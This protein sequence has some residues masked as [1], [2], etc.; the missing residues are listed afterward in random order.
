M[1]PFTVI[2]TRK[3]LLNIDVVNHRKFHNPISYLG[4]PRL[5]QRN[6]N[7]IESMLSID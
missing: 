6:R 5:E 2:K 3:P 4:G 7:S 1:E